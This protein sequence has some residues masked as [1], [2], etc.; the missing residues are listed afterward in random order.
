M[1]AVLR[2]CTQSEKRGFAEALIGA[3][4]RI[5]GFIAFGAEAPVETCPLIGSGATE[6]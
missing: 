6:T 5:L 3:D 2:T 4:D 1:A